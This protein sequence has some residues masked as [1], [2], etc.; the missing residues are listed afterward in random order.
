MG[1]AKVFNC[2]SCGGA[3]TAPADGAKEIQ[4]TYCGNTVIV[5]RE[6]RSEGPRKANEDQEMGGLFPMLSEVLRILPFVKPWHLVV[7]SVGAG[8]LIICAISVSMFT[9]S[10]TASTVPPELFPFV[11]TSTALKQSIDKAK[12]LQAALI[13]GGEGTA[14]GLF[15]SARFA[16]VDGSGNIFISDDKTYRIQKFDSNGKYVSGWVITEPDAIKTTYTIDGLA[17][18]R[19][20]N[21]YVT[22]SHMILKYEGATG[23]LLNKLTGHIYWSAIPLADGGLVA[24]ASGSTQDDLAR[25]DSAGKEIAYY[26]QIITSRPGGKAPFRL[27]VAVDGL[28]TIFVLQDDEG[29]VY[30]YTPDGKFVTKFGAK[31]KLP[32]QFDTGVNLIAVDNQSNVYVNDWSQL[33]IFDANGRFIKTIDVFSAIGGGPLSM[34]INDK[35]ELYVV[36][37]DNKIYKILLTAP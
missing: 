33:F 8:V 13:F 17:A 3:L 9:G 12:T 31:G 10:R 22:L 37:S 15:Q 23:K 5:P 7:I 14:P 4:C 21:V 32:D 30:K 1:K 24:A 18:D 16:A 28:G 34:I 26:P 27:K 29:A 11:E 19:A 2:P 36:E 20:G 35:N 6:L 25:L